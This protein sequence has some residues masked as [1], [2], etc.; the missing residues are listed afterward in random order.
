MLASSFTRLHFLQRFWDLARVVCCGSVRSW[1]KFIFFSWFVRLKRKKGYNFSIRTQSLNRVFRTHVDFENWGQSFHWQSHLFLRIGWIDSTRCCLKKGRVSDESH[2]TPSWFSDR[3]HVHH[4]WKQSRREQLILTDSRSMYEDIEFHY[5]LMWMASTHKLWK[6]IW[7]KNVENV[8]K[9]EWGEHSSVTVKHYL[10]AVEE[11][12]LS[13]LCDPNE[14]E[15]EVNFVSYSF[16]T[17]PL[18]NKDP[19]GSQ[20]FCL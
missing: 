10:G 15:N 6:I 11:D 16:Y 9:S 2:L 5:N 19:E 7:M 1:K 18:L 3:L 8:S 20:F 17:G 13:H 12:L 4:C 14:M